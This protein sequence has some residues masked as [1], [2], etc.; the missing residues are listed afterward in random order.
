MGLSGS[1]AL[2]Q[3]IGTMRGEED[4]DGHEGVK[5]KARMLAAVAD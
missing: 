4:K 5:T 3:V 1:S 2:L